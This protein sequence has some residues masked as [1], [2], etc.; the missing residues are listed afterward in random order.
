MSARY[1]F[2]T[3]AQTIYRCGRYSR[4]VA[5]IAM[6][7]FN[8][9]VDPDDMI[10]VRAPTRVG[11]KFQVVVKDAPEGPPGPRCQLLLYLS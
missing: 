10:Y 8:T 6:F 7:W 11:P 3:S 2:L 9:F 1:I 5:I 4:F